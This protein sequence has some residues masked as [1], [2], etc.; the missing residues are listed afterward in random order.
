[1]S[2]ISEN[3][4]R[5]AMTKIFDMLDEDQYKK[6]V[7]ILQKFEFSSPQK[8]TAKFRKDLPRKIIEKYGLEES[9][10]I[11]NEAMKQI[12]RNDPSVQDL[13]RPFVD[14]LGKNQ[15]EEP[16]GQQKSST[17][18]QTDLPGAAK[19]EKKM[20]KNEDK[21]VKTTGSTENPKESEIPILAIKDLK[22]TGVLGQNFTA[23]KVVQKSGLRPYYT[24]DNVRKI[25]FYLGVADKTDCIKVM[26]YGN[27]RFEGIKEGS[28]YIF[29]D[30]IMENKVM[31]ITERSKMSE[32][33][34]FSVPKSL[35]L[36]AL[37]LLSSPVFTIANIQTIE[38]QTRV[39]V[40]GT[41]KEIGCSKPIELRSKQMKKDKLDFRLEDDTGSIWISLWGEDTKLIHGISVGDF[42]GVIN[43]KTNLYNNTVSLNSTDFT[44][45]MKVHSAAVQNAIVQ[46]V[47]ILKAEEVETELEALVNNQPQALVVASSLLRNVFVNSTEENLK[48]KLVEKI[49]FWAEAEIQGNRIIQIKASEQT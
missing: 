15:E 29:R 41:V 26:V 23:G 11:I 45:I 14:K 49:P 16:E 22:T 6:M 46:V 32:T 9:I 40:E 3:K 19:T 36:E 25:Y 42:V 7:G 18:E 24:Q 10:S 5:D 2:D 30:V 34:A 48:D 20:G 44:R 8:K 21:S 12:P 35:E 31:K 13:L 4:W 43:V 17:P 27:E 38:K 37:K 39:S 28:F 1:M 33:A 47:G